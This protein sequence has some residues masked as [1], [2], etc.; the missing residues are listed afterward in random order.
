VL[1]PRLGKKVEKPNHTVEQGQQEHRKESKIKLG[2]ERAPGGR[3]CP[4]QGAEHENGFQSDAIVAYL[5]GHFED[6]LTKL[7]IV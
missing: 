5:Q 7:L 4:G 2:P 3:K 1:L 6:R